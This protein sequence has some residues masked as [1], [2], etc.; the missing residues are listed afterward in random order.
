VTRSGAVPPAL[1]SLVWCA[2][3]IAALLM[4]PWVRHADAEDS[5]PAG[6]LESGAASPG[7]RFTP[8]GNGTVIDTQTHLMWSDHD[9][10]SDISWPAAK[11]YAE[12]FR[13]GGFSDW[14]L[15]TTSELA[16]LH[17]VGS[18]WKPACSPSG[19]G[20]L[21]VVT[22]AAI[23]LSCYLL[24]SAEARGSEAALISMTY[25]VPGW[26]RQS[27]SSLMRALPVRGSR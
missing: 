26:G 21:R 20:A 14:R 3:A 23:H 1:T 17:R 25:G 18:E 13:G 15:P 2:T 6:R 5:Q 7:E 4:L 12:E 24:W 11:R 16:E 9:N 8:V 10:G 19:S 22:P 27:I